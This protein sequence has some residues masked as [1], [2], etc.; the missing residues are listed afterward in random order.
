MYISS[1]RS[2]CRNVFFTSIY[3]TS[4]SKETTIDKRNIIEF[5]LETKEKISSKSILSTWE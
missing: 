2:P 5:N 1:S 4:K 3:S